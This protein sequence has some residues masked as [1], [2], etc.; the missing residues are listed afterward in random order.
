[1]NRTAKR[2]A[3]MA[4]AAIIFGVLLSGALAVAA[5]SR[6]RRLIVDLGTVHVPAYWGA[7]DDAPKQTCLNHARLSFGTNGA[8]EYVYT[9]HSL[10][11]ARIKRGYY[12]VQVV[13]SAE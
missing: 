3:A 5:K 13:L 6:G 11:C 8:W 12:H 1:M 10:D 2:K 9:G 4:A 7:I